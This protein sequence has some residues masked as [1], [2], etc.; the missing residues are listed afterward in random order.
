MRSDDLPIVLERGGPE[1]LAVQVADALRAAASSGALRVGD[2][3]TSTRALASRLGVSRT[4][5]AAAYDQLLAEGWLAGRRG[6]GTFVTAAPPAS[7]AL[8]QPVHA[9]TAGGPPSDADAAG[10]DQIDLTAGRPCLRVLDRSAWRRAWRT[11]SDRAPAGRPEHAGNA[12]FRRA[13]VEHLLRHRGLNARPDQVLATSGTTSALAELAG[14]LPRGA[15][16]GLEEP[17]YQRAAE[18]ML[19]AGLRVVPVPVDGKGLRVDA[20]PDGL[21]AV[22]CT[23]AHQFP[24]GSRLSAQRRV[25][26]VER[27][28][29][30]GMLIV[31][32]DYDGELRYDVAP[33][34]L[35]AA[36]GP[37]VVVHLGT[38]SKLLTPTLGVGWLVAPPAC[39]ARLLA[40]RRRG[41]IRPAPAGQLVF[42]ALAEYGDLARHLRRLRREL[43]ERRQL[44][45]ELL[46]RA[47][48]PVLGDAAG[49]HL[50]V[51]LPDA[52][53]ERTVVE[54]ARRAGVLAPALADYHLGMPAT[55]G[56][57]VGY[58]APSRD[59][60]RRA[61]AVLAAGVQVVGERAGHPA[62]GGEVG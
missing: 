31:E 55:F 2:R 25:Q 40:A 30:R 29:A 47:G 58:A 15:A 20:L 42:A 24:L 44:V 36:L 33:L 34:P 39:Q 32:D 1:P 41:A 7:E 11:A 26:L 48:V 54:R 52:E 53:A 50:R 57:S 61:V 23:P 59:D 46:S 13:V 12:G 56:I 18:V 4:V 49:A 60:L 17:G 10:T 51:S 45:V 21:A 8:G 62:I 9:E 28:R 22:Y 6:S 37:D 5:T 27:A 43:S 3:L 35:L 14:L 38:S 19:A 16:V